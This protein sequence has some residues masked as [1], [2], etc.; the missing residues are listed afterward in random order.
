VL[1]GLKNKIASYRY[2]ILGLL[3]IVCLLSQSFVPS[4]SGSLTFDEESKL[5]KSKDTENQVLPRTIMIDPH[6]LVNMKQMVKNQN[7][8]HVQDFL[9][10]IIREADSILDERP[11]SVTE[12]NEFPPNGT[13]H[14][15]FALARYEWP[16]PN[17]TDGLPYVSRDGHTNPETFLIRDKWYIEEMVKRVMILALASYFT[18]DSKYTSKAEQLLQVWFLNNDTNMNPSLNYGQYERGKGR[19]N[20]SGVMDAHDI[21]YLVDAVGL[22]ELSPKWNNSVKDGLHQWFTNY[23]YWLM[24]NDLAQR[25]G[26]RK[27]NHGTYYLVQVAAIAYF[28]NKPEITKDVLTSIMQPL[29]SAPLEDV[30]KLITVKINPDGTQPFEIRRANSLHYHIFNLYGLILLARIGDAVGVDLWNYQIQGTGVRKALDFVIP[31]AFDTKSWPYSQIM[32]LE[33]DDLS[34]LQGAIC[35]AAF[36]YDDES[37]IQAFRSLGTQNLTANFQDLVCGLQINY[38]DNDSK[39]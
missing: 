16:N 26:Q 25:E 4:W 10:K 13:K 36:R 29:T 20:P 15:F 27:N 23:L 24:N 17:T 1:G 14:D 32:D 33:D 22:L 39:N 21:P 3:L 9:K 31:Y 12:K 5:T 37:Y 38:I 28:V 35:H 30:S 34:F 18:D 11:K 2:F 7:D 6:S 8:S 19:L